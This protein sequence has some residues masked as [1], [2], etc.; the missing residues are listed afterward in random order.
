MSIRNLLLLIMF[1]FALASCGVSENKIPGTPGY[2]APA[3]TSTAP[4]APSNLQV[5]VQDSD[6]ITVTWVDQSID[7]TGFELERAMIFNGSQSGFTAIADI[8]SNINSYTDESVQSERTY[9]Y[10][11]RAFN[12]GGSSA[13]SAEGQG[14]TPDDILAYNQ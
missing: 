12:N 6:R 13:F 10:R 7:E 11:V 5:L 8:N 3:G 14:T 4:T 1:S 9:I 2:V